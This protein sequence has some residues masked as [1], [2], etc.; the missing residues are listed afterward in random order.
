MRLMDQELL[1]L[2]QEGRI[3]KET[4]LVACNN[5]EFISK[6]VR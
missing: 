4:V 5:Y 2:Y 1:R 3:T 6:R